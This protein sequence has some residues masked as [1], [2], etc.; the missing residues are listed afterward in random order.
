METVR[1]ILFAGL[2]AHKVVWEVMKKRPFPGA[3]ELRSQNPVKSLVKYG[4]LTVLAFLGAQTLFLDLFPISARSTVL[5]FAGTTIFFG[6]LAMAVTARLQLGRNW[7]NIEDGRVLPWQSIV[8]S[9]VYRRVRHP[10]YAG[11]LFLLIGLE[12]ALNSW[13]VIGVVI[14]FLAV[15]RQAAG[16]E[17]LLGQVFPEYRAYCRRTKRFIP[18]VL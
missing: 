10:I 7:S 1:I 11:D 5:Q 12:M 3:Q 13:L 8:T 16:E 14:P 17:K 2:V 6:G 4:K 9:G 18:Y 15:M